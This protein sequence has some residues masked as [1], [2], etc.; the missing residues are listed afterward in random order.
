MAY[1]ECASLVEI[2]VIPSRKDRIYFSVK[3]PRLTFN[4]A[5][6]AIYTHE[7]SPHVIFIN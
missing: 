5:I 1:L 6:I 2:M 4:K 3:K 7:L